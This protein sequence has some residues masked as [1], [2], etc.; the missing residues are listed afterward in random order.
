LTKASS[1]LHIA[2]RNE[3][4]NT[5]LNITLIAEWITFLAAIVLLK[6]HTGQWRWFIALLALIVTTEAIG[7][8]LSYV[9]R[10]LN[11]AF[12]FNILMIIMYCFLLWQLSF[13]RQLI[14]LKK[15][16]YCSI[17]ILIIFGLVNFFF[18]QGWNTYNYATEVLADILLA[19]GGGYLIFALIRDDRPEL[20]LFSEPFFWLSTGILFN[21]TGSFLLYMFL[22]ELQ[23]YYNRTKIDVFGYINYTV[24]ILFYGCLLIAFVCRRNKKLLEG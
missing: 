14:K 6:K 11:N 7:W 20:N 22:N 9:L 2:R 15:A 4:V 17:V 8:Y 3:M 12:P 24:N 1:V 10:K 16:F 5:Y 19:I 23:A 18:L 13:A 21:V